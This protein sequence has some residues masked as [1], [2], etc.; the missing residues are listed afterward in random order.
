M[1][2]RFLGAAKGHRFI[3]SVE[4]EKLRFAVDCGLFR[5]QVDTRETIW[6]SALTRPQLIFLL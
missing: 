6:I 4:T 5:A 2:I 1:K 3:F